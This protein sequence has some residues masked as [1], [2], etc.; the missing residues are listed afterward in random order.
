MLLY[1]LKDTSKGIP[2]HFSELIFV[3][4]RY[5]DTTLSTIELIGFN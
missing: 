4:N 2:Y 3:L 1:S 5:K